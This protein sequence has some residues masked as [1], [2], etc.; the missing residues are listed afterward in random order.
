M[1]MKIKRKNFMTLIETMTALALLS[2][3]MTLLFGFFKQLSD[4]QLLTEAKQSE[5]FETRYV[6]SRLSYIF[7]RLV[8]ENKSK[9]EF[10]FYLDDPKSDVS[11]HHSLVFTF[12][13]G[14]RNDPTF[15]GNIIGRLYVD[16]EDNLWL[17][18]WP[19]FSEHPKEH[20]QKE[21]LLQNVTDIKF[22]FYMPPPIKNS[23]NDITTTQTQNGE[24]KSPVRN[25]WNEEWLMSYKLMP[26]I[27]KIDLEMK[28]K[29]DPMLRKKY[30]DVDAKEHHFSFVLPTSK[31]FIYYPQDSG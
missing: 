18:M 31:T 27:L 2:I 5:S 22:T 21:L 30:A 1:K 19:I 16:S 10:Y 13:N 8:N 24:T 25:A 9:K 6:E 26:A 23:S 11:N 17:A 15:S 7:Q 14:V 20:M 12:D 28:G 29:A 3:V 4:L